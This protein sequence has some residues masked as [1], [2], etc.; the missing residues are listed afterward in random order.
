[1][2]VHCIGDL[3]QAKGWT[4]GRQSDNQNVKRCLL[5]VLHRGRI[6]GG[7]LFTTDGCEMYRWLVNRYLVG[8][9][10]YDESVLFSVCFGGLSGLDLGSNRFLVFRTNNT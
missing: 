5:D 7:S 4:G 8:A 2:G 10:V 9:W 1:M 3:F 6:Y